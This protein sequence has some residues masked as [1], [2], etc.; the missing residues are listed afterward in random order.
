MLWMHGMQTIAPDMLSTITGGF[1]RANPDKKDKNLELALTQL[2]SSIKDMARQPAPQNNMMM[3]M[4]MAMM[5]R[6]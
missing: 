1:A 2:Q 3:P 6:R 4:M 5:M